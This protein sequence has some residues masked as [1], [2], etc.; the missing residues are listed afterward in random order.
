[1]PSSK[2]S[3]CKS[4]YV[5]YIFEGLAVVHNKQPDFS[6]SSIL[7]LISNFGNV[8]CDGKTYKKCTINIKRIIFRMRNQLVQI[9]YRM[10]RINPF[11]LPK[12]VLFLSFSTRDCHYDVIWNVRVLKFIIHNCNRLL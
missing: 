9:S 6:V 10:G 3:F 1:V 2:H 11:N 7:G 5:R 12:S 4:Y 8:P